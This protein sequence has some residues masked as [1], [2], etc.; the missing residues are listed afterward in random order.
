ML[1]WVELVDVGL[2]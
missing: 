1:G 2:C